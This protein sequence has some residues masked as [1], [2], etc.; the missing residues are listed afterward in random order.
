[1]A[2]QIGIIRFSGK[3]G[4][5]VGR[6]ANYK[7]TETIGKRAASVRNPKSTLQA[8]QRMIMSTVAV[9]IGG[10]AEVL[11]NSVEG[12]R[13]GAET[14]NYLRGEWMNMLRVAGML[15]PSNTYR[16][17]KKGDSLYISNPYLVSKGSLNPVHCNI[18]D[19]TLLEVPEMNAAADAATA[20]ASQLFPS[21]ELG[22]QITI[23]FADYEG[24]EYQEHTGCHYLRFAFKDDTVPALV[25]GKL[26]PA[27]IDTN[28][29]EGA[30]RVIEFDV[31]AQTIDLATAMPYEFLQGAAI[32][33]SCKEDGRRSSARMSMP[34]SSS[35]TGYSASEAYESFMANGVEID[36]A[37]DIYLNNNVQNPVLES[38]PEPYPRT[39]TING[40]SNLTDTTAYTYVKEMLG[41]FT[42]TIRSVV[43][44]LTP[45]AASSIT[46]QNQNQAV[47]TVTSV[48]SAVS[49]TLT[50]QVTFGD[51]HV[52]S[53]TKA[54]TITPK[55]WPST[56]SITGDSEITADGDYNFNVG[57]Q[58]SDFSAQITDQTWSVTGSAHASVSIQTGVQC[59]LRVTG[60]TA[61]AETITLSCVTTL[62]GGRSVTATKQ[63]TLQ[64]QEPQ[65]AHISSLVIG[66]QS[67]AKGTNHGVAMSPVNISV[68]IA[69]FDASKTYGLG[70]DE[71]GEYATKVPISNGSGQASVNIP[72][73]SKQLVLLE[74]NNPIENYCFVYEVED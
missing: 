32:I 2:K 37:S 50:C 24:T 56:S 63:I 49:A 12:K 52:M 1:M 45:N 26:N 48:E 57:Y 25:S 62:E 71:D 35:G 21:I 66:G 67:V 13:N 68:Q 59:T 41:E 27:A 15:S 70:W 17:T 55:T 6:K 29:A 42:E 44:S 31:A 11:S 3:L 22:H 53:A 46:S 30:W 69:D 60:I 14:I 8:I 65:G 28:K 16:Y 72:S 20:T 4:E 9:S 64:Y 61:S 39:I 34:L 58:P 40:A 10:F 51:G 19:E 38:E 43:W 36:A 47:I 74:N 23:L 73:T 5:T 7:G 18:V 54:I 33:V